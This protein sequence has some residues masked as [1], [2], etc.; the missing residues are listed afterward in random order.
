ML[1]GPHC[2]GARRWPLAAPPLPSPPAPPGLPRH[3]WLS[4]QSPPF[5]RPF[6]L[7]LRRPHAEKYAADQAAFF[8][9]YVESHLKLSE[10]G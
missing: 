3:P 6:P 1:A 8:A 4:D 7:L 5:C 10:L 9:D 2:R